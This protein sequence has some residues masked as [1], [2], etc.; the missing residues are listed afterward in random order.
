MSPLT[1]SIGADMLLQAA[2]V[3]ANKGD[4]LFTRLPFHLCESSAF[5]QFLPAAFPR[6]P[7]RA[8]PCMLPFTF[9]N[10]LI[11]TGAFPVHS[12]WQA[13]L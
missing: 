9:G 2:H 10:V 4:Q 8:L 3:P 13:R 11:G 7:Q 6:E 12:S 5:Q 1:P